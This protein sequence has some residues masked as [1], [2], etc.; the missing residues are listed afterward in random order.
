VTAG[1]PR[2]CAVTA[3]PVRLANLEP[4]AAGSPATVQTLPRDVKDPA[5]P[6]CEASRPPSAACPSTSQGP[7][8]ARRRH[9]PAAARSAP[10]LP[11]GAKSSYPVPALRARRIESNRGLCRG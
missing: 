1:Y 11:T 8:K 3:W 9:P 4:L 7:A 2:P 5:R 6:P 10:N